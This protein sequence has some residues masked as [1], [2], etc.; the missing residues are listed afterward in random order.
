[1][2]TFEKLLELSLQ[3][4]Q[5]DVITVVEAPNHSSQWIGSIHVVDGDGLP[6][7]PVVDETLTALLSDR[8]KQHDWR[9]P[10]VL[11]IHHNGLYRLFW[12]RLSLKQKA[13]V[14][15]AGHIS[16]PLVHMLELIGYDV[17]VVD[18]R[19]DFANR[20]RFPEA[21][22]IVCETFATALTKMDMNRYQAA[23]IVTRGHRYDLDCLRALIQKPI[24]Y[25][26]MI[27][28]QRR[29]QS[30]RELLIAEGVPAERLASLRAPIGLDIGAQSPA[31]IAL[32]ITAEVVAAVRGGNCLP[33]S[34]KRR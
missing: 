4:R 22:E 14:L 6:S 20:H 30:V 31:E 28:S 17:T 1:M 33:L 15:G 9:Q 18:D 16:Q 25:L 27:G 8:L 26:G 21:T 10:V 13:L 29:V 24:A 19:P 23:I 12:D 32:S 11:D 2:A 34:I 3:G 7:M 5:A